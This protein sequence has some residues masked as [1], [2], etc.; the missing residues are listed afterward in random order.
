MRFARELSRSLFLDAGRRAAL[1]GTACRPREAN[2]PC[3]RDYLA[4]SGLRLWRRP[5]ARAEVDDLVTV[6][7]EV[8]D[9]AR[10][11]LWLGLEAA[12]AAI[13]ASPNFLYQTTIGEP[14]PQNPNLRRYTGYELAERLAL[15]L[16]DSIPDEALLMEAASG[17]LSTP[18]GVRAA[19]TRLMS[20]PK[21]K[22][23][24][25]HFFA[26]HF[27]LERLEPFVRDPRKFPG[28]PETLSA[29][30][31]QE[32]DR[33]LAAAAF[34]EGPYAGQ[35]FLAIYRSSWTWVNQDLADLYGLGLSLA[36][37]EWRLV[38][39]DPSGPRA[40]LLGMA[41]LLAAGSKTDR[42]SP[43]VRGRFV[44]E[45]V[46]CTP[47]ANPPPDVNAMFSDP[48]DGG[49]VFQ[50]MAERLREHTA[51]QL[52]QGC[53][54]QMDPIG[55]ALESFTA[56][57]SIA[58]LPDGGIYAEPG[59]IDDPTRTLRSAR[60]LGQAV[61]T[62]P[63]TVRCISSQLTRWAL[64]RL[65]RTRKDAAL[66]QSLDAQ[67]LAQGDLRALID[68]LVGS[69]QFRTVPNRHQEGELRC[70]ASP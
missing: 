11:D 21:G 14:D 66:V 17:A 68:T 58:R 47:V 49:Q 63:R 23:G 39:H 53:H 48:P 30:M 24:L 38:E 54:R 22:R 19:A 45:R 15:L 12:L 44:R 27:E 33:S 8:A 20:D 57:G 1:V 43:T 50:T 61:E 59:F 32:L 4:R 29:S 13:L 37:G 42:S 26:E 56:V 7:R 28:L 2:D 67:L 36:P 41:G 69:E 18:E 34:R 70:P 9:A 5:L 62:D 31:R 64:G 40:G 60:E 16:W 46:L 55:L 65:D 6:V 25:A 10:H 35:S 3:I 51:N 52:C